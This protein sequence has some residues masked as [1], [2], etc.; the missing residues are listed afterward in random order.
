MSFSHN[1][2]HQ[3][4]ALLRLP[5]VERLIGLRKTWIY[6]SIQRGEFPAPIKLGQRAAAWPES[7]VHAWIAERIRAGRG[8]A[9]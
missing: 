1:N 3:H 8:S 4:D 5:E 2:S 9:K 7:E 6:R